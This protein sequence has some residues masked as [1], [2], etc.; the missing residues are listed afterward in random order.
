MHSVLFLCPISAFDQVLAEEPRVNRLA[1]S[2]NLWTTI[3]SN[4]LLSNTNVILFLNKIDIMKSKLESGIKLV[5]Y[6][7]SY[8][9]RSNDLESASSYL[10]KKFAGIQKENS[11]TSRVFYCHLTTATDRKSTSIVLANIKDMLMQ[12]YL[13]DASLLP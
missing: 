13:E 8:G 10:R 4:K 11:P 12:Q 3:V 6:V 7:N 2:V 1:D 5:D 9:K